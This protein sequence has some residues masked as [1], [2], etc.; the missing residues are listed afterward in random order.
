[1]TVPLSGLSYEREFFAR[2]LVPAGIDEA[3]RGPIAGPVVAAAAI[4]PEGFDLAGVNDSKKMSPAARERVF[5]VLKS[6][7]VEYAVGVSEAR[8]I[9]ET[10]IL[11]ATIKAME[12]AARGLKTAPGFLLIDGDK[13]TTLPVPQRAI[14][15]GDGKCMSIAVASV[16]AKVT[17]DRMM[18]ELHRR[19]PS[20]NFRR[21]KGYPTAEH[22][23][24]VERYG[25]CP[26]HRKSFR[27]TA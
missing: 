16:V 3:G 15:G 23:R 11:R 25:P 8:E 5:N 24:L 26:E 12:R 4:L 13:E 7:G 6:A 1:M 9:D 18:E 14:I 21:H 17:R 20:Y 2:G 19:Y 27:L 10:D 22:R